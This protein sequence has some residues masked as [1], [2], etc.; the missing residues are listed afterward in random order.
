M[1]DNITN[2]SNMNNAFDISQTS[3]NGNY[4]YISQLKSYSWLR[5][6]TQHVAGLN[7]LMESK[8]PYIEEDF[9]EYTMQKK[10]Y[11]NHSY[12]F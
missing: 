7:Q 8:L 10:Y 4:N 11:N 6:V 5:T 12:R 9:K 2:H 3:K 1:V